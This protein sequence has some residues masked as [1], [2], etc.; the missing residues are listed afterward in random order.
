MNNEPTTMDFI[1]LNTSRLW[2]V[3]TLFESTGPKARCGAAGRPVARS[4]LSET[5]CWL[6]RHRERICP[7][8]Y[9]RIFKKNIDRVTAENVKAGWGVVVETEEESNE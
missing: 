1:R 8:C 2:H 6:P 9:N 7:A 5:Q 4:A 3:T